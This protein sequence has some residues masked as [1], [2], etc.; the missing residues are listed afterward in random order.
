MNLQANLKV[1]NSFRQRHVDSPDNL[2]KDCHFQ[3]NPSC[4]EVFGYPC[5]SLLA[6]LDPKGVSMANTVDHT[7]RFWAYSNYLTALSR[8]IEWEH[9]SQ[10]GLVNCV[11]ASPGFQKIHRGTSINYESIAQSLRLSWYTELLLC[12]TASYHELLPYATPWSMVQTYYVIYPAI[13][14]YFMALGRDVGKSHEATLTTIGSDLF[15]CKGRFPHPWCCIYDRDPANPSFYLANVPKPISVGLSNPLRSPYNGDP[16]QHYG[17]FLRTTRERILAKR[18]ELWKTKNNRRSIPKAQRALVLEQLR[19][20]SIFDALYRVRAR[21][22]YHDIDSFAFTS[23]KSF[24][25]TKLQVAMCKIVDNTLTI[26]ETIIAKALGKNSFSRLVKEFSF[27][28]L[29][30]NPQETYLKR[31]DIIEQLL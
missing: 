23:I 29:G 3:K 19:P 18:V 21:S 26:F 9:P 5:L 22:N 10:A 4:F 8:L 16:W 15:S 14:A 7:A 24:D 13:R 6:L 20:T 11:V 2:A 28:P 27:T 30:N 1:T 31:W 17:L 25:Y 12:K